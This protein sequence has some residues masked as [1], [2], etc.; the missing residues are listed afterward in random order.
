M[1]FANVLA[2]L[3][4]LTLVGSPPWYSDAFNVETKHTTVYLYDSSDMFGFA[5]S[6]HRD[7]NGVGW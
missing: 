5:V 6:M 4:G 1:W 3:I 7:K 2:G